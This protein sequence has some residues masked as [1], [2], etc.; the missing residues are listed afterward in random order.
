MQ[1]EEICLNLCYLR[2][3]DTRM[4]LMGTRNLCSGSFNMF[5]S[6]KTKRKRGTGLCLRRRLGIYLFWSWIGN[7]TGKKHSRFCFCDQEWCYQCR[8]Q[9]WDEPGLSPVCCWSKWTL[10]LLEWTFVMIWN[11]FLSFHFCQKVSIQYFFVFL[12]FWAIKGT[13]LIIKHFNIHI[14]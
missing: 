13:L 10:W 4:R 6:F 1:I 12:F 9:Y 3:I 7:G 2:G 14:L 11:F 5:V 8:Y